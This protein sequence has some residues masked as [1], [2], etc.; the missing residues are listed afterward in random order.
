[1]M[2]RIHTPQAKGVANRIIQS[3]NKSGCGEMCLAKNRRITAVQEMQI[4]A[5]LVDTMTGPRSPY[6]S[7][8]A[9]PLLRIP[10][11]AKAEL[12]IV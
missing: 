7:L 8:S 4:I 3:A 10:N 6:G 12:R 5:A 2:F 1:M 11:I 9:S